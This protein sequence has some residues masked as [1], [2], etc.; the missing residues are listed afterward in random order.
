MKTFFKS[1]VLALVAVIAGTGLAFS[2]P[3]IGEKAPEFKGKT[4]NGE[5]VSLSDFQGKKVILEWTNHECPF[6]IKH[7]D[8]GNMQQLQEEATEDGAVWLS[9]VSSAEGKQGYTDPETA[10]QVV[11]EVGAKATDRILDPE[12][13]IGKAYQAKTTPHMFIIDEEGMLVY[14]GAIDDNSSP[15]PGTVEGAK[16]YV[17]A[18]LDDLEAGRNV[19]VASTKPYGCSV[20]YDNMF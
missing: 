13:E 17:R 6:V 5:I 7:Y 4:M 9:I 1:S 8:T 12:G 19:Q 11:E 15:R 18:A 3:A 14:Q 2:A 20:K 10:K 16:N